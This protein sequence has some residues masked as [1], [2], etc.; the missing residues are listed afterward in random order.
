MIEISVKKMKSMNL[1]STLWKKMMTAKA[2]SRKNIQKKEMDSTS[3]SNES[4][5]T[6]LFH[7]REEDDVIGYNA[8]IALTPEESKR[9]SKAK[10]NV[11]DGEGL[12]IHW[13]EQVLRNLPMRK[14]K[15]LYGAYTEEKEYDLESIKMN[16]PIEIVKPKVIQEAMRKAPADKRKSLKFIFIGAIK[17]QVRAIFQ[18]KMHSPI[19][20]ACLDNRMSTLEDALMGTVLGNLYHRQVQFVIHPKFP[21][22]LKDVGLSWINLHIQFQNQ[23]IF[24]HRRNIPYAVTYAFSYLLGNSANSDIFLDKPTIE[25]DKLFEP[26][27]KVILPQQELPASGMP[28]TMDF[29]NRYLGADEEESQKQIQIHGDTIQIHGG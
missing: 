19:A 12:D 15:V 9:I 22:S 25:L 23:D 11:K 18:E 29:G 1:K 27:T 24:W 6:R 16:L 3:T 17:V 26:V 2:I 8:Q 7:N 14:S 13:S 20:I 10:L 4:S 21:M 5:L 28:F